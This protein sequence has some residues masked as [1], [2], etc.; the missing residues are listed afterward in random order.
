MSKPARAI[1]RKDITDLARQTWTRIWG[2]SMPSG[3]RVY[4]VRKTVI[5]Q[6]YGRTVCGVTLGHFRTILVGR[7]TGYYSFRT[8]VHELAHLR[9][10]DETTDHG[11]RW[12][13]EFNRVAREAFGGEL[14][15]NI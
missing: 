13:Y 14:E 4:L 5:Q 7:H 1:R 12:E 11:P 8:L 10:L 6:R 2:D 3:W 9:T 15:R